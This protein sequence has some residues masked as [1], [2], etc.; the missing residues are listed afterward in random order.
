MKV[1]FALLAL[2]G[3][4]A[5]AAVHTATHQR[6]SGN[7]LKRPRVKG[8]LALP[9]P[10]V[11]ESRGAFAVVI[12]P[13]SGQTLVA[14][15]RSRTVGVRVWVGGIDPGWPPCSG[16]GQYPCWIDV[17]LDGHRVAHLV[18]NA[19]PNDYTTV[20][21]GVRVGCTCSSPAA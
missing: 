13:G 6:A 21:K 10:V 9:P 11:R 12:E 19:I 16:G 20:L 1:G 4:P 15:P 7:P 17:L 5:L 3:A 8:R 2:A 14:D 18:K